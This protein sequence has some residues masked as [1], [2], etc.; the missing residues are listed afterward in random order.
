[1][2]LCRDLYGETVDLGYGAADMV[3]VIHVIEARAVQWEIS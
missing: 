3:C 2:A 1:M